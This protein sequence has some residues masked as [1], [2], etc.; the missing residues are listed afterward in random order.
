M[1]FYEEKTLVGL[2]LGYGSSILGSS[3]LLLLSKLLQKIGQKFSKKVLIDDKP[4]AK[5]ISQFILKNRKNYVDGGLPQNSNVI[6]FFALQKNRH[7]LWSM[8]KICT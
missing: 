8:L 1:S 5:L 6:L 7:N 2:T 4:C 3:H